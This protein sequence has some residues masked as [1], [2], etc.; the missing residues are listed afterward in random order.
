MDG[1]TFIFNAA[2]G[3][4]QTVCPLTYQGKTIAIIKQMDYTLPGSSLIDMDKLYELIDSLDKQVYQAPINAMIGN[5]Q[6]NIP[7]QQVFD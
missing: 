6:Q 1:W 3:S 2:Y 4:C 5:H 7:E